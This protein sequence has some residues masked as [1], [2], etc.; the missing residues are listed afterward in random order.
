MSQTTD[1]QAR[2]V[3]VRAWKDDQYRESLPTEVREKL[4]PAPDGAAQM[5]DQELEAAAGAGTPIAGLVI[6]GLA[7]GL[8][9]EEAWD[10]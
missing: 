4:P 1:A 5:S 2:D 6:G 8:S 7:L 9:A 10:D 3:I